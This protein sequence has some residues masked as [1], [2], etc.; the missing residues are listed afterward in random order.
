MT[1][2]IFPISLLVALLI[3]T[4]AYADEREE[5]ETLRQTTLN[6]IQTLVKS[7]ILTQEKADGLIREAKRSAA[8]TVAA[9]NKG[10]KVVRVP[11]VPQTVRNEIKEE[12]KQEV[13]TQAKA[14]GWAAP[15]TLPSWLEGTTWEAD[16]RLRYQQD[17]FAPGNFTPLQLSYYVDPILVGNSQ[18]NNDRWRAR[19]RFG[20][21]TKLTDMTSLGFRI[22]TGKLTDPISTNQTLGN[23]YERYTLGVDRAYINLTPVSWLK[24]SGGRIANPFFNTD[25]VWDQDLNFDGVAATAKPRL[26]ESSKAFITVGAFPLTKIDPDS[27]S[28]YG[29]ATS[30]KSRWLY[31]SQ[32]GLEWQGA[33]TSAKGALA[34]YDYQ[35]VQGISNSGD[36]TLDP[37][38]ASL[39]NRTVPEF[40]QKGNSLFDINRLVT[41][42]PPF[43]Y[44]LASKFRE[45][46]LTGSLDFAHF[47]PVHVVLTGDYVKN[48]GFDRAEILQRTGRDIEP[49]TVG[50]Q[51]GLTVGM[52]R[53]E[54]RGE[55][56]V[57]GAYKYLERDAV[58]DAF[59]DSDFRL[60]GTD[61]KG[62]ILG[63]SY[64]ID[65][66]TWLTMR[67]LSADAIDGPPFSVDTL[68]LD[69][70]ARF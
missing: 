18:E 64:G 60:G 66:N 48:I 43:V 62:Y 9:E 15:G 68:Q 53:I 5:L 26:S 54:K 17:R 23:N 50:Y 42:A 61:A 37:V 20:M 16:V 2:N 65:R 49:R 14:E 45:L 4:P 56:Q 30:A 12:L 33:K 59:T 3:S 32:F 44:A 7:G 36:Y 35:N 41:G 52:P 10:T 34:L 1:N 46:N 29:T 21:E 8:Q 51:A 58:L 39:Y 27:N 70:N 38:S 69:L 24:L 67:W 25:L 40:S 6:L 22:A 63:G 28:A 13:M 11:Y 57:F 31:A 55:W 47:D 19:L